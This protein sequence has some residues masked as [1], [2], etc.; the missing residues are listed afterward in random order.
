MRR[1]LALLILPLVAACAAPLGQG[2][3]VR[4]PVSEPDYDGDACKASEYQQFRGQDATALERVLIL[5]PVRVIRPGQPV[6]K[7][8]WPA[9]LNFQVDEVGRIA[10][11]YCG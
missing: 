5:K 2:A 9:R 7:D 4:A 1:W 8:H 10:R 3:A 6:T 11:I